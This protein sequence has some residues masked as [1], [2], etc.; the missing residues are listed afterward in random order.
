[1]L[2]NS[3]RHYQASC[4]RQIDDSYLIRLSILI[5][6]RNENKT[7]LKTQ[8]CN[9]QQKQQCILYIYTIYILYS[10]NFGHQ[11]QILLSISSTQCTNQILFCE[12]DPYEGSP[13]TLD[14]LFFSASNLSN[15]EVIP[16]QLVFVPS[17]VCFV[18]TM[19]VSTDDFDIFHAQ[20][21][22]NMEPNQNYFC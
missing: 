22:D 2:D 9:A 1:M 7:S 18:C 16:E 17:H 14:F 5:G 11:G 6:R 8:F 20:R 12:L 15:V 13:N 10:I 4:I 3:H 21:I 19:L